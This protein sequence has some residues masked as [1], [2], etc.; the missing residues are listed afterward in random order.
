MTCSSSDPNICITCP[1]YW[2]VYNGTCICNTTTGVYLQ[3]INTCYV[4]SDFM[5]FCTTCSYSGDTTIAYISSSFT[6]LSCNSSAGYFLDNNKN[7]IYCF[8]SNCLNCFNSTLCA[9]CA[10]GYFINSLGGCTFCPLTGCSVCLNTTACSLCS[11]SP[12]YYKN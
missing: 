12:S 6:C 11:T 4:C 9:T 5:P 1:T 3:L 7:C 8:I 2:E 10:S